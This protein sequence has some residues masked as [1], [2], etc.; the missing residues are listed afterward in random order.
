MVPESS[1]FRTFPSSPANVTITGLAL[2]I[3]S[4]LLAWRNKWVAPLSRR[5]VWTFFIS[6]SRTR[7]GRRAGF[8]FSAERIC[9]VSANRLLI[10]GGT[11]G[12]EGVVLVAAVE[13]VPEVAEAAAI[14]GSP[15]FLAFPLSFPPPFPLFLSA[16]PSLVG[17][18]EAECP[19]PEHAKHRP[20]FSFSVMPSMECK[21][22]HLLPLVHPWSVLNQNLQG[23][24]ARR[25]ARVPFDPALSP[26]V[27]VEEPSHSHVPYFRRGSGVGIRSW[28]CLGAQLPLPAPS[29]TEG[30]AGAPWHSPPWGLGPTST[31]T[32]TSRF[33]K[34]LPS[35]PAATVHKLQRGLLPGCRGQVAPLR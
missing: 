35:S 10:S 20:T 1:C 15:D 26:E 5:R 23:C 29:Q 25:S 16:S 21:N 4:W 30:A 34:R 31:V 27:G 3:S 11:V 13:P 28:R 8:P 18:A 19:F 33:E 24:W 32:A 22:P 2:S 7:S 6:A 9:L 12:V 14:L 17:H